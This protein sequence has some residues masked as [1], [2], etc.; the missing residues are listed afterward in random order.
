MF[1]GEIQERNK[2]KKTET[3]K[4][5]VKGCY[6][7]HPYLGAPYIAPSEHADQNCAVE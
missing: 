7:Q 6:A 1:L 5:P 4:K 3:V 2:Q